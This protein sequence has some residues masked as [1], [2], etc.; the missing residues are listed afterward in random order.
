MGQPLDSEIWILHI[1][2]VHGAKGPFTITFQF[3]EFISNRKWNIQNLYG[4]VSPKVV[5]QATDILLSH[6]N[7]NEK[8]GLAL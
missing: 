7:A 6:T 8:I 2:F 1:F 3:S 5:A 4:H